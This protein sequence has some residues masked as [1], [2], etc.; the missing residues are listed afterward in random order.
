MSIGHHPQQH[1]HEL[2]MRKTNADIS[3]SE[4]AEAKRHRIERGLAPIMEVE[5]KLG[6]YY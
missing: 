6:M 1:Q 4:C 3:K 5:E 2:D